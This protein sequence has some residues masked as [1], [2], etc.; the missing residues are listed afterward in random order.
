MHLADNTGLLLSLG[1]GCL[2]LTALLARP[3]H[4]P[5]NNQ[6]REGVMRNEA[7]LAALHDG[8]SRD[9]AQV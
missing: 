6:P 3:P 8:D 1:L 7:S 9:D 5:N 4:T 2:L